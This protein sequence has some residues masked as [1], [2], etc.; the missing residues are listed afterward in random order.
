MK[1]N[2]ILMLAV[3][4]SGCGSLP[5]QYSASP[6][7]CLVQGVSANEPVKKDSLGHL[8]F[9]ML[10]PNDPTPVTSHRP[11][12]TTHVLI[13]TVDDG[14]ILWIRGYHLGDKVWLEPGIHKISVMC[15][16]DYSWGTLTRGTDID[17]NVKP[18]CTYFLA[19]SQLK[20]TADSPHV[21]VTEKANK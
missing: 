19:A 16:T 13:R 12:W 10:D 6:T 3:L 5:T 11:T 1:K 15:S 7:R 2:S 20:D 21:E 18:G 8:M 14:E 9:G 4:I 17:L